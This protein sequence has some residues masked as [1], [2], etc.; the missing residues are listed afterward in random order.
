MASSPRRCQGAVEGDGGSAGTL[1]SSLIARRGARARRS[2]CWWRGGGWGHA[3]DRGTWVVGGLV[4]LRVGRER[5]EGALYLSPSPTPS[6]WCHVVVTHHCFPV[7]VGTV[8]GVGAGFV[9]KQIRCRAPLG[10]GALAATS[11]ILA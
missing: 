9:L 1:G 7:T 11:M 10:A 5:R 6:R 2:L 3:L 8:G 4:C